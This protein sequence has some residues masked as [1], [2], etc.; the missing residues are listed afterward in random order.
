MTISKPELTTDSIT[1][2][3]LLKVLIINHYNGKIYDKIIT[4]NT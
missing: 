2:E 4:D 1:V 3:N